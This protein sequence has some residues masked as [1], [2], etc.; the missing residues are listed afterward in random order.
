MLLRLHAAAAGD[1]RPD[2]TFVDD[3]CVNVVMA[4]EGYPVAPRTGDVISGID[5]AAAVPG[6][7]VFHAGVSTDGEGRLVTAGGRV[8][9][10]TALGSPVEV[11]RSRAYEAAGL[12]SWP[13]AHYR[14]DIAVT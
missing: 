12:I 11:A 10:V 8:L 3:A 7:E 4:A 13:G 1:P 6:V 9:N 2:P 5:A 14:K